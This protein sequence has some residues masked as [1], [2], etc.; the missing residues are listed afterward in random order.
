[1]RLLLSCNSSAG[2]FY[3]GQSSDGRFHPIYDGEDLGSYWSIDQAID[4]LCMNA[5]FSVL[6]SETGEMLDTSEIGLEEDPLDWSR[7]T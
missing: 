3:I 7:M 1:M 4:D 2:T 5:T 6:H